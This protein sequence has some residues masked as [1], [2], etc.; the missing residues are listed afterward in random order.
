MAGRLA[1]GHGL[2]LARF[3]GPFGILGSRGIIVRQECREAR[4][5]TSSVAAG[6][7]QGLGH[8][9]E[10]ALRYCLSGDYLAGF[11]YLCF[12]HCRV[13]AF[14]EAVWSCVVLDTRLCMLAMFC[15]PARR[16]TGF[17]SAS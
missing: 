15:T 9:L 17:R 1:W 6:Q 13:G 14:D 3:P 11:R 2:L 12:S 16:K 7:L 4:R 5:G 10:E 8:F